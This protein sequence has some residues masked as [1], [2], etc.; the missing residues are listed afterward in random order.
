M[1]KEQISIAKEALYQYELIRIKHIEALSDPDFSPSEEYSNKKEE[2]RAKIK[3][4]TLKSRVLSTKQKIAV[5]IAATLIMTII[6]TACAFGKQIRGFFVNFFDSFSTIQPTGNNKYFCENYELTWVP[7][8]YIETNKTTTKKLIKI[9]YS[10]NTDI[11]DFICQP[12]SYFYAILDT[13]LAEYEKFTLEDKEIYFSEK[14]GL[15]TFYWVENDATLYLSCN[16]SIQWLDIERMILSV[17]E[18]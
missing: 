14:Y 18:E 15:Y 5:I 12:K 9:E 1:T 16:T 2:I 11:I 7:E 8:D 3:N 13:Q 4:N 17:K 10:N 6:A